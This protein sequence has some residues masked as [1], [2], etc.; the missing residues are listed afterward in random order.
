MSNSNRD[1]PSGFR[2][3]TRVIGSKGAVLLAL[4]LALLIALPSSALAAT[5]LMVGGLGESTLDDNTMKMALGGKFAG[6]EWNR[7]NVQW[8]ADAAPLWGTAN[9]ADSVTEGTASLV[10]A[11]K[12]ADETTSGPITILGTSAGSLVVDEAMRVLANDPTW[13]PKNAIDYVVLADSTQKLAGA[14]VSVW[15]PFDTLSGYT[16]TAPPVTPFKLTVVTYEYDGFADFPDKWWNLWAVQNAIAGGLIL[17]AQTWFVGPDLTK[18]NADVTVSNDGLTTTYLIHPDT[19]PLVQLYPQ[20]APMQDWLKEQIDAGYSRNDQT[21]VSNSLGLLETATLATAPAAIT[22]DPQSFDSTIDP[23]AGA[24]A[25]LVEEQDQPV[26]TTPAAVDTTPAAVD[27]TPAA[28]DTTVGVADAGTPQADPQLAKAARAVGNGATHLTGRRDV[29]ADPQL[30]KAARAVGN[31][32]T[33]LTGRRD[34][35]ADPNGGIDGP[36][37]G[38]ST[39]RPD[40]TGVD[41]PGGTSVKESLANE[42]GTDGTD[43]VDGGRTPGGTEGPAGAEGPGSK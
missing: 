42:A 35:K 31:G 37:S 40:V 27:T 26:D 33:H 23:S 19:L 2:V 34:V 11:I 32:A 8:P 30:A 5:V 28:V 29:K 20:L 25:K 22:P 36:T 4:V 18:E 14:P 10:A 7:I 13:Q 39:G 41:R 24:A 38:S 12:N 43:G 16:Y 21:A 6:S 3:S 9:L 15:N 17:H 1:S